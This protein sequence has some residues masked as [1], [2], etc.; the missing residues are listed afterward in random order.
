MIWS[1]NIF[2]GLVSNPDFYKKKQDF[3]ATINTIYFISV[4]KNLNSK[5]K[6]SSAN[7]ENI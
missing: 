5:L 2:H 1:S 4:T 6:F 3:S 7:F